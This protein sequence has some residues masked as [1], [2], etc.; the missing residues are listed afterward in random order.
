MFIRGMSE[1]VK[2]KIKRYGLSEIKPGDILVTNDAYTTGSHL[3]H[4][5][6]T[7]PVFHQGELVAFTCC[8][9][10]WLDVGGTLGQVTTDIYSEGIQIPIVKYRREGVVNQE[11]VD[12][13]AMNVRLSE[14]AM[15]DLRAQITAVTT[16]ERRF[17]E[18][19][20]RYGKDAVLGVNRADHGPFRSGCAC[21]H[22]LDPRR[23][24]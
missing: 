12:I 6:F 10:H 17:L 16:G 2:A 19:V 11:L 15:G 21:K 4:F 24:L 7:M 20:E 18:L 1:T 9:A 3:N 8:M 13:I 5:T 14:R 22:A 23:N